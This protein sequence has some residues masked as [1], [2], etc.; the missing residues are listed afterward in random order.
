MNN[1]F[2]SLLGRKFTHE[3]YTLLSKLWIRLRVMQCIYTAK[4]A[5]TVQEMW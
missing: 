4:H 5:K 3:L 1:K 2:V